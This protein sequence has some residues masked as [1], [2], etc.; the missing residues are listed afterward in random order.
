MSNIP[1]AEPPV[2]EMP[3]TCI[4][5]TQT[6]QICSQIAEYRMPG[7]QQT[8]LCQRHYALVLDV[9]RVKTLRRWFEEKG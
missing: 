1:A 5:T 9:L 4:F 2:Q 7:K 3:H 6:G 8:W